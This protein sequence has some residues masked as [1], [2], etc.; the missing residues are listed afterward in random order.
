M[1]TDDG[2]F[3]KPFRHGLEASVVALDA[4]SGPVH[5]GEAVSS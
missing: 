5:L 4:V 3:W 2:E 1:R